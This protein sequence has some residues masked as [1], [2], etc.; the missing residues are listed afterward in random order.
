MVQEATRP[1]VTAETVSRLLQA[2][3][4]KGSATICHSMDEYV[5]FVISGSHARYIDRNAVIALQSPE[6]HRLSLM[7][8]VF[9]KAEDFTKRLGHSD[10]ILNQ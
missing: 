8:E 4:E 3:A 2:A 5:Q 10:F 9:R 1:M 7:E 6:V